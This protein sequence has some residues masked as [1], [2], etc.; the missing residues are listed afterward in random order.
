[1]LREKTPLMEVHSEKTVDEIIGCLNPKMIAI[2]SPIS[3]MKDGATTALRMTSFQ[4]T[5]LIVGVT[6][7]SPSGSTIQ[8][9]SR[10]SSAMGLSGTKHAIESC[11]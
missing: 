8:L 5:V 1:M 11:K 2:R 3:L 9:R 6:P 7:V 10:F 4:N